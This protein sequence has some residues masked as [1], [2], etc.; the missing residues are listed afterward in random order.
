MS[1]LEESEKEPLP[2]L[3]P[4]PTSGGRLS[5][6]ASNLL[7]EG[8]GHEEEEGSEDA[9]SE[10][11]VSNSP[12]K[13]SD[14]DYSYTDEPPASKGRARP[15]EEEV[16]PITAQQEI[17][18]VSQDNT[19]INPSGSTVDCETESPQ[20][21]AHGGEGGDRSLKERSGDGGS[22]IESNNMT[23]QGQASSSTTLSNN[24]QMS[25]LEPTVDCGERPPHPSVHGQGGW[26]RTYKGES[27]RARE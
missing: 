8:G 7:L 20:T 24:Q 10:E 13:T 2:E 16:S 5:A 14:E 26:R 9:E 23:S 17:I 15:S 11:K 27:G 6:E 21:S 22:N 12:S 19:K 3:P 4:F 18:D 1:D 25:P